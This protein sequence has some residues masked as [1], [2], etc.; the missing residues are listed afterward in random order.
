MQQV[1]KNAML[2]Y[3]SYFTLSIWTVKHTK[4][5]IEWQLLFD[6]AKYFP[7]NEAC[8]LICSITLRSPNLKLLSLNLMLILNM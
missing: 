8:W 2:V 4:R 3:Y 5:Q 7:K 6:K 1:L